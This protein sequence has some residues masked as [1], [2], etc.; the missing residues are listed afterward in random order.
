MH[1]LGLKLANIGPF[2]SVELNFTNQE[3]GKAS[4]LIVL[5]GEN[6]T[7]K[8]ILLD[9]IR[10]AFGT[11]FGKPTRPIYREGDKFIIEAIVDRNI[12]SEMINTTLHVDRFDVHGNPQTP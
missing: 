2:D 3:T 12:N 6:G 4:Q 9:S 1:L 11:S 5:T 8:S 7:G 10:V